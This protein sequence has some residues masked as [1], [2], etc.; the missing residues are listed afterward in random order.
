[1]ALPGNI[2]FQKIARSVHFRQLATTYFL[3]IFTYIVKQFRNC[4][5]FTEKWTTFGGEFLLHHSAASNIYSTTARLH[6]RTK[7]QKFVRSMERIG[8]DKYVCRVAISKDRSGI[9]IL[10]VQTETA[11]VHI[12][13]WFLV[14]VFPF[15][16]T[17]FHRKPRSGTTG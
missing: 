2:I 3:L 12:R 13:F 7:R 5:Y 8:Q 10:R 15:K 6:C 14:S 4:L 9:S 11:L 16:N 17:P 1:M